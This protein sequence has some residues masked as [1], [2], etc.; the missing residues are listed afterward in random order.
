MEHS[1]QR[2][3]R[4][5]NKTRESQQS[6]SSL[7]HRYDT[8]GKVRDVTSPEPQSGSTAE[9]NC[10]Q[11]SALGVPSRLHFEAQMASK[12]IT[13]RGKTLQLQYEQLLDS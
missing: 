7:S 9:A 4:T 10:N 5:I 6:D 12:Y 3:R 13:P 8:G 11:P 2:A 1:P